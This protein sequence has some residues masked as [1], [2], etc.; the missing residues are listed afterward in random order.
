MCTPSRIPLLSTFVIT[1]LAL[2]CPMLSSSARANLV[3]NGGFEANIIADPAFGGT[4]AAGVGGG[5]DTATINGDLAGWQSGPSTNSPNVLATNQNNYFATISNGDKDPET[6]LLYPGSG[7][8]GG[9]PHSGS[10]AAVFPNF[11]QFDGYISQSVI[12][13][14]AGSIYK[15]SFW[16]SNQ[17]GDN[18]NNY[19]DVKWGGEI[20]SPGAA[21]T[22]GYSLSGGIPALPG[23]IPVPTKWTY[24]EFTTGA[25]STE[26]RLSFIGG[27]AAAGTLIDDVSVEFVAV[28][29]VN[30]LGMVMGFGLLAFGAVARVRRR[31]LATA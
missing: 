18:A 24:Y 12:G 30:S 15:I 31:S 22:G 14:V 25:P 4:T 27:N 16:L 10:V 13:V 2:T 26:A 6:G 29:E 19:M 17:V 1:A 5:Q 3:A 23:A 9:G 7:P 28:P 21:I 20:A 8:Y 11:P